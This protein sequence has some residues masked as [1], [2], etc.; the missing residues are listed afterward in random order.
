MHWPVAQNENGDFL[1]PNVKET[2]QA[3]EELVDIGL[4]KS[5][6]VS[7][8]SV[9]KIK[10]LLTYARIIPAMNQVELH[11]CWKQD[12]LLNFCEVFIFYFLNLLLV[13]RN[14]YYCLFTIWFTRQSIIHEKFFYF[15]NI[16]NKTKI[17]EDEPKLLD[18]PIIVEMGNRINKTTAQILIRYHLQRNTIV[19]P[20]SINFQRIESNLNVFDWNISEEDMNTLNQFHQVFFLFYL[21]IIINCAID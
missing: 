7:N 6:G 13:K 2:Y 18:N 19:I 12:H 1:D 11:P 10:E 17:G 14:C 5:I 16:N 21:L 4:V 20:K 8:F 9:R 15:F 3:M